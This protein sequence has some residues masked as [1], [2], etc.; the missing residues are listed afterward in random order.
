M[1]DRIRHHSASPYE[2]QV[3]FCRALRVGDRILVSGSAPIGADGEN[4]GVGDAAAQARRCVSVIEESVRALGGSLQDVVRTRVYLTRS[5]DWEAVAEAHGEAFC[6]SQPASTFVVVAELL[7]RDWLVE[8]EAEA[9][10]RT[11]IG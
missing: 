4:V 8:M 10:V 2:T 1:S 6:A 5:Q 9:V 7:H 11:D 3:G